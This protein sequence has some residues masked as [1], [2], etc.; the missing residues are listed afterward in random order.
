MEVELAGRSLLSHGD[1]PF[2]EQGLAASLSW[3]PNPSSP[4]GPSLWLSQSMGASASSG[5]DALLN[6][7]GWPELETSTRAGEVQ[8][9]GARMG[10]GLLAHR[11][12]LLI[13][14]ELGVD[15]SSDATITTLGFFL[16]PYSQQGHAYPWQLSLER[17]QH[18]KGNSDNPTTRHSLQLRSSLLL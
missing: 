5:S 8:Q 12:A 1:Q 11:D 16:A 15:L 18:S 10:Y 6:P 3:D 4:L 13:T 2:Q 9:F 14:P 7:T 17:Q